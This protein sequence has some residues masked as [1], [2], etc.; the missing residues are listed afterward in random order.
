MRARLSLLQQSNRTR[1]TDAS[2]T[3]ENDSEAKPGATLGWLPPTAVAMCEGC[4]LKC[5]NCPAAAVGQ[6][7]ARLLVG[8]P[9]HPA[10][11][12]SRRCV[13]MAIICDKICQL[14]DARPIIVKPKAKA[15]GGL[16]GAPPAANPSWQL[17]CALGA[18]LAH[19]GRD[20]SPRDRNGTRNTCNAPPAV[21]SSVQRVLTVRLASSQ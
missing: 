15:E 13:L 11:L 19:Q 6:H 12:K 2:E 8:I 1:W 10:K 3:V 21:G 7:L 16:Q 20:L 18:R 14:Q 9:G 17:S 4:T 5:N